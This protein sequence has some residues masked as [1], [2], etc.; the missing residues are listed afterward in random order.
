MPKSDPAALTDR[1][2]AAWT[3]RWEPAAEGTSCGGAPGT[4]VVVLTIAP[5][6]VRALSVS[7]GL[8]AGN[9]RRPLQARPLALG[10]TFDGGPCQPLELAETADEQVLAIDSTVPVSTIRIGVDRAA[11]QRQD[12]EPVLRGESTGVVRD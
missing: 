12:G 8:L 1:T 2:E 6:R 10:V 11:A 7:A 3:M 5:T 9:G 4:G